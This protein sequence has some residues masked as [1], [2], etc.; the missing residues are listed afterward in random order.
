MELYTSSIPL[1]LT[2]MIAVVPGSG[3]MRLCHQKKDGVTMGKT[4]LF[5]A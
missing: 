5:G 2:R 4:A 1:T 3:L